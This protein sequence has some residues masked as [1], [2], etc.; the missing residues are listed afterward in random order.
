MIDKITAEEIR[1]NVWTLYAPAH[2]GIVAFS[3]MLRL[4]SSWCTRDELEE[5]LNEFTRTGVASRRADSDGITYL[6]PEFPRRKLRRI[7]V[8]YEKATAELQRS[9]A[10][11][12]LISEAKRLWLEGSDA[13]DEGSRIALTQAV[14]KFWER[15]VSPYRE[16][17]ARARREMKKLE[18]DIQELQT[19]L[20]DV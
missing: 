11:S 8:D 4:Y 9:T 3:D 1:A 2:N 10:A 5:I 19:L 17:Q 12:D 13:L 16:A 14:S 15:E 18:D 20:G 6:F 7:S